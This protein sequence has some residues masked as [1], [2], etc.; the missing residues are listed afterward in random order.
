MNQHSRSAGF[1]LLEVIVVVAIM[2]MMAGIAVPVAGVMLRQAKTEETVGRLDTVGEAVY[3]YFQDTLQLPDS[4]DDLAADSGAAGW[5]GPYMT[6]GFIADQNGVASIDLDGWGRP[7][8]LTQVDAS[9]VLIRSLGPDGD[10]KGDDNLDRTVNVVPLLREETL[11]RMDV[12]NAAIT[13]YNRNRTDTMPTLSSDVS[14]AFSTLASAGY[15]PN[16][17]SL[18]SDAWGSDFTADP[19]GMAPLVAVASPNVSA[20][21]SDGSG[22]SGGTDKKKKKK[23]KK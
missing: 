11:Q 18:L 2:A 23:K 7:M 3:A 19:P 13:A 20:G 5:S 22:G 12:L 21:A 10:K 9:T 6:P 14:Q 17:S 8:E 16:S 15:L 1:S 4:F